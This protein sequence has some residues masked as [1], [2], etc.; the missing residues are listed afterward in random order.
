MISTLQN[1][2][3]SPAIVLILSA[4]RQLSY[5]DVVK[6]ALS[7]LNWIWRP[8]LFSIPIAHAFEM[9]VS[10]QD[11][12]ELQ[13]IFEK[14]K[15]VCSPNATIEQFQNSSTFD[16]VFVKVLE[17]WHCLHNNWLLL[18]PRWVDT[19]L[20]SPIYQHSKDPIHL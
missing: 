9:F 20:S 3:N 2:Q 19:I 12:H 10:T 18:S 14:A 17:A 16:N 15:L 1:T 11:N 7:S 6:S 4:A 5:D 8:D 13:P